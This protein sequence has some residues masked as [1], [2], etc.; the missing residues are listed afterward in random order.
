VNLPFARELWTTDSAPLV[1]QI[2]V[3][4]LIVIGKKDIQVDW[5]ADGE[6]LQHAAAGRAH[7]SL[8]FPED[9]NHVLKYES[10]PRSELNAAQALTSYNGPDTRLDRDAMASIIQ[11]LLANA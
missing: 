1:A 9:A 5:R 8:V 6:R 10:R 7:I 11:W 2:A 4:T 3:R